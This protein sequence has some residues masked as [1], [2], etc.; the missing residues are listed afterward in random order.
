MLENV[1]YLEK[2]AFMHDS[3]LMKEFIEL[4]GFLDRPSFPTVYTNDS[5]TVS[6]TH[7]RKYCQN[8]WKGCHFTQHYGFY[9]NGNESEMFYDVDIFDLPYFLSPHV[10]AFET[11]LLSSLTA[12]IWLGQISYQQRTDIYNYVHGYD[13]IKKQCSSNDSK[14]KR[15]LPR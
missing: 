2:D 5:G 7:F 10:T 1:H 6:A 4:E 13:S 12:E 11:K 14:T 15:N 8:N 3:L 9:V